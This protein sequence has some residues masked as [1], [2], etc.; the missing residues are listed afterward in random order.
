MQPHALLPSQAPAGLILD[1]LETDERAAAAM[2]G[3][4]PR[5]GVDFGLGGGAA[6]LLRRRL[7]AC[8]NVLT[9]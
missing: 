7:C 2:E 9:N 5:W 4:Q 1:T 3:L 6:G 8:A